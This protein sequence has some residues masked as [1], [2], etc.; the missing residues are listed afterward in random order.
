MR[1]VNILYVLVLMFTANS[2]PGQSP[3]EKTTESS[4]VIEQGENFAVYA[5]T[6]T[7]TNE[8]GQITRTTTNQFTLLENA[9]N[10]RDESGAW[11]KSEDIIESFPGGAVARR[12]PVKA[13][14][15]S[16]VN[17]E[18]VWDLQSSDG[19]RLRGGLR[20]IQVKDISSGKTVVLGAVPAES[21]R[22]ALLL[23]GHRC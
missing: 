4:T 9:L 17:S 5:K 11:R 23:R 1:K 7:F 6:S 14:F 18:T 3:S 15:S 10:Y 21:S 8:A 12:G 20:T 22:L 19:T 16:D 13:I 2:S